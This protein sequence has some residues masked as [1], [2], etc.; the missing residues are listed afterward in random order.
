MVDIRSVHCLIGYPSLAILNNAV[1]APHQT[2]IIGMAAAI[3]AFNNNTNVGELFSINFRKDRG[4][5]TGSI[6][7]ERTENTIHQIENKKGITMRK[8]NITKLEL[9]YW[10]SKK[11]KKILNCIYVQCYDCFEFTINTKNI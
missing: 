6:I 1:N 2:P 11:L 8:Y 7:I 9:Q 4:A 10:T 3:N 5:K